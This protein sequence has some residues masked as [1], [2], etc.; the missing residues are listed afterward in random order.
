M[1][2]KIGQDALTVFSG[3]EFRGEKLPQLVLDLIAK[4]ILQ[5][6]RDDHR[7]GTGCEFFQN[8]RSLQENEWNER[9]NL[10]SHTVFFSAAVLDINGEIGVMI[11]NQERFFAKATSV[12]PCIN[13]NC[14]VFIRQRQ[15]MG[16]QER[17]FIQI[18]G[19]TPTLDS[20]LL[21][22]ATPY[23]QVND[24][25]LT[26]QQQFAQPQDLTACFFDPHALTAWDLAYD[27]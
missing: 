10:G 19:P 3:F 25:A 17:G 16:Q 14:S 11:T 20:R 7:D 21:H 5:Q 22:F 2:K 24:P 15:L 6:D 12:H 18:D 9:I 8:M 13:P 4:N 23:D 27:E 1:A 26:L